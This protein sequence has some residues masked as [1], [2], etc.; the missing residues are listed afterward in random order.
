MRDV[1]W[2]RI[3]RRTKTG[4]P[5]S[6][7]HRPKLH[8]Q[9]APFPGFSAWLN[10]AESSA[11]SQM[12]S[13]STSIFSD[14]DGFET[15]LRRWI[16]VDLTITEEGQFRSR[17]TQIALRHLYLAAGQESLS[18]IAFMSM[19]LDLV[20]LWWPTGDH[21][22]QVW[23]G[24]PTLPGEMMTLGLGESL[25]ARTKGPSRWAGLWISTADLASYSQ[26]LT[27]KPLEGMGGIRSWQ[28][29]H[30]AMHALSE[31]H[32]AAVN[33]FQ[34]RPKEVLAAGAIR[35]LEQQLIH[36][37]VECLS[38]RTTQIQRVSN[39]H[40]NMMV[41][42]EAACRAHPQ[43]K[44]TLLE[45]CT[46][47]DVP[48]RSLRSCCEQHL[49]MGPMS[50]LRLRRMRLVRDAL[51]STHPAESQVAELAGRYGFTSMPRFTAIYRRMFGELPSVTLLRRDTGLN[52]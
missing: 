50:Y 36:A 26:A 34:S 35:G 10:N 30:T 8:R 9:V 11:G 21:A 17:L 3:G 45:L 15:T 14:A 7:G 49:G 25:H 1:R 31:L 44:L 27:G 32:A 16:D 41:R 22:S 28:P 39:Q 51:R 29:D 52:I 5:T 43:R 48:E 18:R 24:S 20:L 2:W 47:L 33:L 46:V 37:L 23:C 13:S 19:R 4:S 38:G 12:P 42:F 6:P 40:N